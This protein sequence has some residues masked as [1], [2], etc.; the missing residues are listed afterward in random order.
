MKIPYRLV[1]FP[2][3]FGVKRYFEFQDSKSYKFWE[4][5][6]IG[7]D[8]VVKYGKIGTAGV[9]KIKSFDTVE[10]AEKEMEKQIK[11]KVKKGYVETSEKS[12]KRVSKRISVSY[13][14]SEDG[15]TLLGKMEAFLNSPQAAEVSAITIGSWEEAFDTS[16]QPALDLL[17]KESAK[18]PNLRELFVGDMDYEECEISWIIQ[19]NYEAVFKAFPN[20]EKLHIKG[21]QNLSL[22]ESFTLENLTSLTIECGGLPKSV[23]TA[24]LNSSLPNLEKLLIYVG[25]DD[26]GCSFKVEDLEPLFQKPLFPKMTYLGVVD[27]EFQ[28]EIALAVANAPVVDQLKTLDLSLGTLGDKGAEALLASD[29]IKKLEKLDLHYNFITDEMVKKVKA[30][31]IVVD[32]SDRQE[33]DEYGRYPSV[34]E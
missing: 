15:K 31:G 20:L 28:D 14:E 32:I 9:E 4:A 13:D 27:S 2:V 25:I 1:H 8:C 3:R 33:D 5:E 18:V 6:V 10:A 16:P 34:T 7:T 12:E 23:L 11:S 21:S 22:G 24:I 29:K 30:S 26:Y 19:G 17:A